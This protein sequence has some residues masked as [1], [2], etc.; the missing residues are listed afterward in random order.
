MLREVAEF[1]TL[2][3]A[4]ES[5]DTQSVRSMRIAQTSDNPTELRCP[6]RDRARFMLNLERA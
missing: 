5:A 4:Q 6:K 1:M 3:G 2:A